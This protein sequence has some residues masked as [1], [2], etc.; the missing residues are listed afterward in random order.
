M[1]FD[2]ITNSHII[3][4]VFDSIKKFGYTPYNIEKMN[5]YFIF[6]MGEDSVVHFRLRGVWKHWKFGMWINSDALKSDKNDKIVVSVFCQHDHNIDK[7]KPS[8]S[9]LCVKFTVEDCKNKKYYMDNNQPYY[10]DYQLHNM[11]SMI[12]RHPFMCYDGYCGECT[13]CTGTSFIWNYICSESDIFYNKSK[14][15]FYKAFVLPYCRLKMYIVSKNK[16]V[17]SANVIESDFTDPLYYMNIVFDAKYSNEDCLKLIDKFFVKDHYGKY[18]EWH[19]IAGLWATNTNH[20]R[21]Y[22]S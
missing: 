16:M 22:I 21:I 3:D 15:N 18:D 5:G 10:V 7:F 6:D 19:N 12:H 1:M 11:L 14:K 17:K 20:E 9:E 2:N 4:S 8:R 13:G